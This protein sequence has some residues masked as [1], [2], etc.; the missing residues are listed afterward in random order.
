MFIAETL[1]KYP[2]IPMLVRECT[3]DYVIPGSQIVVEKSTVVQVPVMG[4]HHDPR[5][6]A[7]PE[8]FDPDRFSDE[9][10]ETRSKYT[11]LPFGEGPRICI[12]ELYILI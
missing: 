7:R 4:L 1:R 9:N 6:Y 10:K 2:P 5:Y 12:G 3:M 8:V 11:Y